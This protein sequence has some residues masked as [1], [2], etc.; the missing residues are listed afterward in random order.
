MRRVLGLFVVP[1]PR[2][3]CPRCAHC[4]VGVSSVLCPRP[5]VP[6]LL[7]SFNTRSFLR[8]QTKKR[9]GMEERKTVRKE[10][11][12]GNIHFAGAFKGNIHAKSTRRHSQG[13]HQ[14]KPICKYM[15]GLWY[16][17]QTGERGSGIFWPRTLPSN[18]QDVP[19]ACKGKINA[20][21][22]MRSVQPEDPVG[23][24]CIWRLI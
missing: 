20:K 12:A 4:V 3:V 16:S 14:M 5:P 9:A 19:G 11:K 23:P 1:C 2:F 24:T 8:T 22:E 10:E 15:G 13:S 18:R 7:Y 21:S 17:P 6:R